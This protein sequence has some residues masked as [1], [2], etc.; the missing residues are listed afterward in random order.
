[1]VTKQVVDFDKELGMLIEEPMATKEIKLLGRNWTIQ[2]DL[3]SFSMAMIA[4]GDATGLSKFVSNL[5]V[6]DQ[7]DDF[8]VALSTAKGLDGDKLGKL[9][10]K[11]IEVAGERPTNGPLPS[12]ATAKRRTSTL[13]SVG[14]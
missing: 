9:L 3:N 5:V 4:G 6:E 2:C 7:R 14:N 10:A 12:P 13:R 11:L 1:M 8:I